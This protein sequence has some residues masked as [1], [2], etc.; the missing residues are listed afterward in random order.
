MSKVDIDVIIY[1]GANFN[2]YLSLDSRILY[3]LMIF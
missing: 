1:M 2:M 3:I